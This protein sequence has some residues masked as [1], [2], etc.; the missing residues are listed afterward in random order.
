M[1]RCLRRKLE[2]TG[3]REGEPPL[4]GV[5]LV[6]PLSANINTVMVSE[7]VSV[8][9]SMRVSELWLIVSGYDTIDTYPTSV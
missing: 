8:R 1:W 4:L 5:L 9:V 3:H 2:G 7:L 6:P